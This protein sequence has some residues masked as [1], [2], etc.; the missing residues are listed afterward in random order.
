VLSIRRYRRL[1]EREAKVRSD[2]SVA[3]DEVREE[4]A[5]ASRGD[6]GKGPRKDAK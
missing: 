1:Q 4:V 6:V 5:K 3:L 2:G